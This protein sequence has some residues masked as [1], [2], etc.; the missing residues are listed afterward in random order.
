MKIMEETVSV[1]VPQSTF[2]KLEQ[3]ARLTHRSVFEILVSAVETTLPSPPDLS[4]DVADELAAMFLL[5]DEA[6]WAATQ[7]SFS[8]AGQTRLQQLNRLAGERPLT[9]PETAEHESLLKSYHHAVLRRAQAL[10]ILSQ[11]GHPVQPTHS[12]SPSI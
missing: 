4:A 2:R 8:P 9:P 6:L 12:T 11:R 5:S 10:A 1:Q 3:A 7:P